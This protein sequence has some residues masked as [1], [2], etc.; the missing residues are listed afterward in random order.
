MCPCFFFTKFL[1]GS[2]ALGDNFWILL[3]TESDGGTHIGDGVRWGATWKNCPLRPK[4]SPTAKLEQ[5]FEFFKH[6]IE[7]SDA[8]WAKKSSQNWQKN[9]AKFLKF[10]GTK[11]ILGRQ[12]LVKKR[13]W[14][15]VAGGGQ[16]FCCLGGAPSRPRK[17][18]PCVY[19][20]IAPIDANVTR[21]R[22]TST[23][24]SHNFLPYP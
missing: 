8:V 7:L 1:V 4:M 16:N 13:G 18:T 15:S 22:V 23:A 21:K 6:K 19:T 12:A 5:I 20:K 11:L 24:P 14:R 17:I 3:G 9:E 10:S 2:L